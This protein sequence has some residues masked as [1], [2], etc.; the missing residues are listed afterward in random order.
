MNEKILTVENLSL[1]YEKR[2]APLLKNLSFDLEQ[3]ETICIHGPSGCGKSTVIWAIMGQLQYMGGF[4][5]G[6]VYYRGKEILHCPEDLDRIR[7]RKMAMVPQSSMN[8]FNPVYK[9]ERTFMEVLNIYERSMTQ[10][11]KKERC[12]EVMEIVQLQESVLQ[13]YQNELSGGMRQRAAIALAL[14]LKP[15][16]LILDEATTG[17]DVLVEANILWTLRKIK[18]EQ[19]MSMLVVSHDTRIAHAFCD[20]RIEL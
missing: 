13:K 16:L 17:L 9:M 15:E 6:A 19:K 2:R 5:K 4:A 20:R 14:L 3:E 11:Q 18:K 10:M 12:R 8:S 1:G 7:W